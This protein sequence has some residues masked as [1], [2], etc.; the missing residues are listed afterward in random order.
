MTRIAFVGLSGGEGVLLCDYIK[1]GRRSTSHF[2][3]CLHL[4][5]IYSLVVIYIQRAL[6]WVLLLGIWHRITRAY[7]YALVSIRKNILNPQKY[8]NTGSYADA[9]YCNSILFFID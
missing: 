2:Y 3:D 6:R 9:V 4:I 1:G 8:Q 5:G 7:C